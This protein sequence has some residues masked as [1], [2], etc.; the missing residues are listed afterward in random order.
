[1]NRNNENRTGRDG[2]NPAV[3]MQNE[4]KEEEVET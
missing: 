4:E 1:M 2:N 3:L